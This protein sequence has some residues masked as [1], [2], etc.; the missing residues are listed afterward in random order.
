MVVMN[1]G[2]RQ[3]FV[4]AI[5]GSARPTSGK[6]RRIGGKGAVRD[7]FSNELPLVR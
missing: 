3:Y 4:R 2:R 1:P 5:R 6:K 7:G